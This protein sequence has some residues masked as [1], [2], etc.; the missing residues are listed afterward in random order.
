MNRF[1]FLV[2]TVPGDSSVPPSILPTMTDEAP[3]ASAFVASPDVLVPPSDIIG[4][5]YSF[6]ILAQSMTAVNCGTPEPVITRVMQIDP[7]PTPTFTAS[8]PALIKSSAPLAVATLPAIS[9]QLGKAFL[10]FLIVLI[11]FSL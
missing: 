3:A 4:I 2:N 11:A 9:S 8:T 7:E 6:P 5:P 1:P 10:I